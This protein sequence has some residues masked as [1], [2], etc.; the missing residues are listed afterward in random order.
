MSIPSKNC[1]TFCHMLH[2]PRLYNSHSVPNSV[3][4]KKQEIHL[5]RKKKKKPNVY[6][7]SIMKSNNKSVYASYILKSNHESVYASSILKSNHKSFRSVC[8]TQLPVSKWFLI[9]LHIPHECLFFFNCNKIA[10][11]SQPY[12]FRIWVLRTFWK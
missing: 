7:S 10:K 4:N 3:N 12:K 5:S 11:N 2:V 8:L 9:F 6:A 1:Q